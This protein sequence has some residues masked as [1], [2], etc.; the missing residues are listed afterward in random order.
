[1]GRELRSCKAGQAFLDEA[2][3]PFAAR[4]RANAGGFTGGLRRLPTD[5]HFG[6]PLSTVRR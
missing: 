6:K 5:N 4:A 2:I 1:L 3:T